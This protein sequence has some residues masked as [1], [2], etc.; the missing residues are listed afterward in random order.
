M[1]PMRLTSEL[2]TNRMKVSGWKNIFHANGNDN[3]AG[4]VIYQTKQTLKQDY[5]KRQKRA[6]YND[7]G[8]NTRRG[9]YIGTYISITTLNV[10]GKNAPTKRHKLAEWIQNQDLQICCP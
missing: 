5:N 9:Y 2:N 3:K 8:I 4:V 6:L 7:K 10:N 1:L